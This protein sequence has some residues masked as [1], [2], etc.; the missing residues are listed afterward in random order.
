M[1]LTN[2]DFYDMYWSIVLLGPD[3]HATVQAIKD[4]IDAEQNDNVVATNRIRHALSNVEHLKE[5][6]KW[7]WIYTNNVYTYGLKIMKDE[8]A[9]QVLSALFDELLDCL[10]ESNQERLNDLKSLHVIP[11]I[12]AE[13]DRHAKKHLARLIAF[14]RKKW[15]KLFLKGLIPSFI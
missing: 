4:T 15:N 8:F 9:Y 3:D 13:G 11:I 14:Y 1:L 7:Q 2:F 6:Q 10:H 12:L 5:A